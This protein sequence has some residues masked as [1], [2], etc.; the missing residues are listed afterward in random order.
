MLLRAFGA[1]A[2]LLP[3]NIQNL[4]AQQNRMVKHILR[5]TNVFRALSDILFKS[6]V[7]RIS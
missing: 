4:L 7:T 1:H 5:D 6:Q 2:L 3:P